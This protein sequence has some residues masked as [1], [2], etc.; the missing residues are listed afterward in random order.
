MRT[1]DKTYHDERTDDGVRV[2]VEAAGCTPYE[3][4]HVVL[5]SPTGPEYGFGGSGPSDLALSIVADLYDETPTR[6][7]L[8]LGRCRAWLLHQRVKWRFVAA[9]R[10]TERQ[11][12][13]AGSEVLAFCEGLVEICTACKGTGKDPFNPRASDGEP[14]AAEWCLTCGQPPGRCI[15]ED[16]YGDPMPHAFL[17]APCGEC[18][19]LAVQLKRG[20]PC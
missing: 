1:T 15:T 3:M 14:E 11:H 7:Q 6:T 19:G 16:E 5:H 2:L 13:I 10:R 20:A 8:E 4:R 12:T 9:L 17:A 18:N